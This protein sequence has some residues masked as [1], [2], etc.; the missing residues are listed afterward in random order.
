MVNDG[1]WC[2]FVRTGHSKLRPSDV[3]GHAAGSRPP[4]TCTPTAKR[5]AA[6]VLR[7]QNNYHVRDDTLRASCC[8]PAAFRGALGC[9]RAAC[10]CGE[11]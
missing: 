6:H 11:A 2:A 1:L 9:A 7:R 3:R 8:A 4:V 10:G 5:V